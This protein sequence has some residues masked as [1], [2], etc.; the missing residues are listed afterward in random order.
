MFLACSFKDSAKKTAHD[1]VVICKNWNE[2]A[3]T[4]IVVFVG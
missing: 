2:L 3:L 1:H 4:Q